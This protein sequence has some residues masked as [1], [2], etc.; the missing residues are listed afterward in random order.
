MKFRV[1]MIIATTLFMAVIPATQGIA[2]SGPPTATV[3]PF[4]FQSDNFALTSE[5][6]TDVV[7]PQFTLQPGSFNGWHVHPGPGFII[8]TAGTLTLYRSTPSGCDVTTYQAGQGFTEA[9][10]EVHTARNESTTTQLT[11]VATFLDVPAGTGAFRTSVPAPANCP[12]FN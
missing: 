3:G 11:G 9:P 5:N 6:P 10:G 8:V 7:M 2:T 1:P 4:D 12:S